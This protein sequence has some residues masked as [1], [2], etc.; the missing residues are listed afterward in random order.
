MSLGLLRAFFT[1]VIR[2]SCEVSN[3]HFVC[4]VRSATYYSL[5]Y[6][7]QKCVEITKIMLIQFCKT[8]YILYINIYYILLN[9]NNV[10]E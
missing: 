5:I 2:T 9:K 6:C 10:F 3:F 4:P 1:S 8:F 7:E